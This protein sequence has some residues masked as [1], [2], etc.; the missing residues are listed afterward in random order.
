MASRG[1][2]VPSNYPIQHE[3][4]NI[5]LQSASRR[6]LT[7]S[8]GNSQLQLFA[9][10][11]LYHDHKEYRHGSER[12]MYAIP[13]VVPSV[14]SPR[15][16]LGHTWEQRRQ[17]HRNS[18]QS[19]YTRNPLANSPPYLAYRAR[20]NREGNPDDA[21]WPEVLEMAFLDGKPA[22]RFHFACF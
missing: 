12:T 19:R 1:S 17:R 2:L 21:K 3:Q 22:S 13:T 15:Q 14:P 4:S 11:N 10:D 5:I 20:Q 18:R 7:A 9:Q 6:P 16:S 8:A